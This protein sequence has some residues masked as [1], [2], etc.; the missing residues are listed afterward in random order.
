MLHLTRHWFTDK[1]IIG[2]LALDGVFL[3]YILE[4]PMRDEKPHCIPTGT[5]DV[6]LG[7]SLRFARA[8]WYL[9]ANS[10][11]PH[12]VDV[13][14]FSGILIHPGNDPIDTLGCL[15]PGRSHDTDRVLLSV[16]AWQD[17]MHKVKF[18]TKIVIENT[19]QM[20]T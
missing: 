18:P 14:G 8:S 11:V 19:P 20:E 4:P 16:L 13:P 1:S 6:V 3:C 15:L 17:I 7:P 5:Y 2:G 12:I 10:L 9:N